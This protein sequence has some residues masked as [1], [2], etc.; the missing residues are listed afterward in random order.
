MANITEYTHIGINELLPDIE[1]YKYNPSAIQRRI[2]DHLRNVTDGKVDIIDP[3]NPFVFLL[4]ASAVNTSAAINEA[5]I[6]LRKQY[7]ALAQTEEELYR[8]MTDKD[9]ITRFSTPANTEFTFLIQYRHMLGKML[10][11]DINGYKKLVILPNTEF[12]INGIIFSLQYPIEIR[13]YP[14]K[15]LQIAYVSDNL[16][17]LQ[18][19]TTNIIPY[20]IRKDASNIEWLYFNVE[21]SQ[22]TINTI[23]APIQASTTFH[24]EIPFSDKY[25][26][27]R[28]FYKTTA[29][30]SQWQE[31]RITYTDQVYDPFIPTAV[32]KVLG[33]RIFVYIPQVYINQQFIDG[34]IRIDIYTTRGNINVNMANYNIKSFLTRFKA[35][36]VERDISIYSNAMTETMFLAYC[37]KLV[38]GGSNGLNFKTVRE[39]VINNAIGPY[40]MP[41]TNVQLAATEYVSNFKIIKNVDVVTNRIFLATRNLPTPNNPRLITAANL[42]IGTLVINLEELAIMTNVK[43]N[44]DRLTMMSNSIYTEVNGKLMLEK[45]SQTALLK[46]LTP[47]GLTEEVNNNTYLYCPYYYVFDNSLSEFEVRAYDLDRPV[48][49]SFSFNEQNN[50][51]TAVVNTK[52][53]K[54]DKVENGYLMTVTTISDNYYIGLNDDT[55]SAQLAFLPIGEDE[56]A[57]LNAVYVGTVITKDDKRERVYQF[58]IDSNH[59]I[60]NKD[61]LYLTSFKMYR[62]E[63]LTTS[64]NLRHKFHLFYTT[65][66]IPNSYKPSDADKLL[67]KFLMPDSV[68]I[69]HET[70]NIEFGKS[71]KQLWSQARS[72]LGGADYARYTQDIPQVY[73][74]DV[75]A[76]D[77]DTG[78]IFTINENNELV[79]NLIHQKGEIVYNENEIVYKYRIGDVIF[80]E[81]GNPITDTEF[82]TL[83][84]VDLLLVEGSYYFANQPI[85]EIYRREIAKTITRWC[86]DE[87]ADINEKLLEQTKIY[88]YPQKLLGSIPVKITSDDVVT[89]EAAQSFNLELYV[90]TDIYKNTYIRQSLELLTVKYLN[91]AIKLRTVS[92]SDMILELKYR[93][94]ENVISFNLTGLGGSKNY[95]TITLINDSDSLSLRK[96]LVVKEDNSLAVIEDIS[97]KFIDYLV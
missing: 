24:K 35:I 61:E 43:N 36:D 88:Y 62:N 65:N 75:Y 10:K 91:D 16:S 68:V 23:Y 39:L 87:L 50:T 27:C 48:V 85:Y 13:Y 15:V 72:V 53:I 29:T 73:E 9:F 6:V 17:P 20:E 84:H 19:L 42:T 92:I 80:D 67:G 89:I 71:L 97:I 31:F 40:Q 2:L 8:H 7:P 44:Q 96:K 63:F 55:V 30:N 82:Y 94:G 21:V 78:A 58:F 76:R 81:L 79:Y 56:Y 51:I 14:T 49:D 93:Y 66:Y 77:P 37:D 70:F 86:T 60:N 83:R 33:N 95:E 11:D 41:I 74:E 52:N 34:N 46:T 26:F 38:T 45:T 57:Y 59:D 3:T 47:L 54:L 12:E 1:K 28:V 90:T 4:E 32:I 18:T 69:T 5:N 22:F 25:Y 64:A